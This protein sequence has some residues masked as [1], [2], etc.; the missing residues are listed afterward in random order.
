[1]TRI[2]LLCCIIAVATIIR[3]AGIAAAEWLEEFAAPE[4]WVVTGD[5]NIGTEFSADGSGA[6]Q[7]RRDAATLPDTVAEGPLFAAEPGV[8]EVSAVARHTLYSPDQSFNVELVAEFLDAQGASLESLRV[9]TFDGRE[10]WTADRK[11]VV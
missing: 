6:L 3:P 2:F 8:W 9:L 4:A 5:G 7:M 10:D 11:S 1:M